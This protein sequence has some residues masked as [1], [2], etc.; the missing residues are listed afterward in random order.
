LLRCQANA[1]I[2]MHCFKHVS[3]KAFGFGRDFFDSHA[4]LSKGGMAVFD[5]FQ[6]HLRVT[7]GM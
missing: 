1:F 2:Y 6:N 4:F 7:G 5:N 3:D